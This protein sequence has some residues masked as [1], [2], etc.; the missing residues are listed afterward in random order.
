MPAADKKKM[1]TA[2]VESSVPHTSGQK[3]KLSVR[4]ELLLTMM[5]NAT[6]SVSNS[7]NI[8]QQMLQYGQRWL[9]K[10]KRTRQ[11]WPSRNRNLEDHIADMDEIS[12]ESD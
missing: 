10:G 5:K 4:S 3:A 8:M 1:F 12:S 2:T 6:I 9:N 11:R 7:T